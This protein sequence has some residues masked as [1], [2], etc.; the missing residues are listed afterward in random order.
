MNISIQ[1]TKEMIPDGIRNN[2]S[3]S[4]YINGNIL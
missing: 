3:A 1:K 4:L 2:P